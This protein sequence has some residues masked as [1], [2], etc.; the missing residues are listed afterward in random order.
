[1][2]LH[3]RNPLYN[4]TMKKQTI[5][6]PDYRFWKNDD[7]SAKTACA[8]PGCTED[9]LY[10]APRSSH[11]V[12]DY[13]WFCLDHVR[14]YN[15]SWNY[16]EGMDEIAMEDA[17]RR[18]TTWERP[19]W[20]FGT[21]AKSPDGTAWKAQ[22]DDP[23]GVMGDGSQQRAS[24]QP[25]LSTDQRKAWSIFGLSPCMDQDKVKKRYKELAKTHHPDANGGSRE[26]EDRLKTINWAYSIL[27][28][29][30]A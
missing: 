1:M 19:S 5:E 10:K 15:K 18:S 16:F 29:H 23:F 2:T 17:I 11:D 20:K 7:D 13:I 14:E 21:S 8:K 6:T 3:S 4:R 30:F 26:A 9:G 25:Q 28:K 24:S 12:R 22:F 27:K